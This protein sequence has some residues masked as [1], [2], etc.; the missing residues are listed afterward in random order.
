[1]TEYAPAAIQGLFNQIKAAIPAALMGGILGDSAHTY[2]YHRGRNYVAGD[3]YSVQ[4]PE[5]QQGD[6]EAASALDLSWSDA[7]WQY[8]V[9][10]RLLNAKND[11]RM[12]ACREFYGSTDG[13]VVC[14]WDYVGGYP[15]SSDSSHLWHI[16]LSILRK[17]ANDSAAL[18]GIASVITGGAG[19]AVPPP[20]P[21]STEDDPMYKIIYGSNQ[22]ILC[23][24]KILRLGGPADVNGPVADAPV[25]SVSDTQWRLLTAT[26]GAPAS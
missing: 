10:Q 9:S 12:Y 21:I 7:Q 3:D 1:M 14:G 22:Y 19:G 2:G 11:S 5:D 26:Y 23:G 18:S 6:G 25:W 17:Y 8:T 16:H 15:V 13:R 4:Y 20:I 24:G